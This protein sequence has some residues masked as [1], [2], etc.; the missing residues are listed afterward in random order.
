MPNYHPWLSMIVLLSLTACQ[1]QTAHSVSPAPATDPANVMLSL[2]PPSADDLVP[3]RISSPS[4]T[5]IN[6]NQETV[7]FVTAIAADALNLAPQSVQTRISD[8]Y[9]LTVTGAE[10]A[11]GIRLPLSQGGSV[12][13]I[14]PRGDISSGG[15]IH[16]EAIA[17]QSVQLKA[18]SA[19]ASTQQANTKDNANLI[20]TMLDSDSLASAGL[21]DNSSALVIADTLSPGHYQLQVQQH[22]PASS[23]YLVHVKEKHSPFTLGLSAPNIVAIED[24]QLALTLYLRQGGQALSAPHLEPK[25]TLSDGN[26]QKVSLPLQA[27]GNHWQLALTSDTLAAFHR[28]NSHLNELQID[29]ETQVQGLPIKRTVK[30]AF[31]PYVASARIQSQVLSQWQDELPTSLTFAIDVHSP[32]RFGLQGILVGT[33]SQGQAQGILLSQTAAWITPEQDQLTLQFDPELIQ[34]SG[35][36]APFA[37]KALT[38]ND[39]GQ[40]ARISYQ[41]N[42][43]TLQQ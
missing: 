1:D 16:A 13:R 15:L 32:G 40:M 27:V 28:S 10:L 42:A 22:L 41:A 2:A 4:L 36:V 21:T 20:A 29:I 25:V 38:L 3:S 35:L 6:Q 23:Q 17:P 18:I 26:L 8:E 33:D 30:T 14:A 19:R 34:R 5:A 43:L 7:S 24:Q 37:L 9:W 31:K 11:Q 12:V 39:Q